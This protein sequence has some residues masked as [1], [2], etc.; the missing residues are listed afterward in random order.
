MAAAMEERPTF[1]LEVS[2]ALRAT[3]DPSR[4]QEAGVSM[5]GRELHVDRCYYAEIDRVRQKV[6]VNREYRGSDSYSLIGEHPLAL[7]ETLVGLGE[8][9]APIICDDVASHPL[10]AAEAEAYRQR[11]VEAFVVTPLVKDGISVVFMCVTMARPRVWSEREVRLLDEVAERTWAAVEQARAEAALRRNEQRLQQMMNVPHV[12]IVTFSAEGAVLFTND[13][14]L[15]IV[16]LT[17]STCE[18]ERF[19]WRDLTTAAL[20][21]PGPI[22]TE[23]IRKDGA[24]VWLMLAGASVG[25]GT[26]VEYIVDVTGRK[27]AEDHVNALL[28]EA[29]IARTRADAENRAKDE[30]IA[31]LG[32]EL[33]NPLTP[34][35]TGLEVLKL[36]NDDAIV[37]GKIRPAMERQVAHIVRLVDDLLD[38]SRI[39][40]G[41]IQLRREPSH[42]R[43]L[44]QDA[45]DANRATLEAKQHDLE[46]DAI[47]DAIIDVDP[48]RFI[49]IL[50]NLLHNAV[51]FTAVGGTIGIRAA[52]ANS[53]ITIDIS[54]TGIG[55]S[56][57]LLGRAF[58]LFAQ[59]ETGSAESGLGIGLTLARRL[60]EMHGGQMVAASDGP[61]KG[62]VISVTLPIGTNERVPQDSVTRRRSAL[63]VF[64]VDD[65]H[66]AADA[67]AM[68]VRALGSECD[69]A[70]DGGAALSRIIADPPDLVLLDI[71]MPHLDGYEVC[72]RARKQIG[73]ASRIVALTGFGQ[74]QDKIRAYSAG[75]DSHITK[76]LDSRT[77]VRLLDE[78]S[79]G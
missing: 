47:P 63:R 44:I 17:R 49:Q 78:L 16:G 46:L 18:T 72:R 9:G 43:A 10:F 26:F 61:G 35:R 38:V 32:H 45:V 12:G 36:S 69:V 23:Y 41:K 52:V 53:K 48:T 68:L 55:M 22:E 67:T 31:L 13:A 25:D 15:S 79:A 11:G 57:E 42:L 2:D 54:D 4:I 20:G 51:K 39:T 7:F 76:P 33:R 34:I 27:Q 73:H 3:A 14:F 40:T 56:P 59:G 74:P 66:D 60:A 8:E 77:L 64:V 71:G 6:V 21:Q 1:L 5:L 29:N 28:A 19:G 24:H 62:S 37:L 70:Y 50:S 65:N 30:F 75:F 58:E